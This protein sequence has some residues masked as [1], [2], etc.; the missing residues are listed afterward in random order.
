M[1]RAVRRSAG[2]TG[3]VHMAGSTLAVL[4]YLLCFFVVLEGLFPRREENVRWRTWLKGVGFALVSAPFVIATTRMFAWGWAQLGVHPL[5]PSL[6]PPGLPHAASA[7]IGVVAAAYVGDFVY[8]WCHRIQHRFFWRFHAV[9]HSIREMS[10]VTAY[11]HVSETLFKC[12]LY[13]APLALFTD[14]PLGIPVLGFLIALQGY[15][16]H[17]PTRL[18]FGPLGRFLVDN[19]FHRV[20]HAIDPALHDRNF[21]VFTTLWDHVFGT[22][23]APG[24]D[25]WPAIGVADFP[26]P[27]G[28]V[29]YL[30]APFT[31][32]ATPKRAADE[33]TAVARSA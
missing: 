26:E 3:L 29:E 7:L 25:E 27:R 30:V 19:R 33:Q 4:A 6:A 24:E 2:L 32:R 21:G 11:H 12:A 31:W 14:D 23:Y 28:V 9:H 22:A 18:H 8:Y 17:S 10:G 1:A 5:L 15:Y 20:H 16:V 13:A